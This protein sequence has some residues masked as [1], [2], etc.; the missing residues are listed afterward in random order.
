MRHLNKIDSAATTTADYYFVGVDRFRI[1]VRLLTRLLKT[2]KHGFF[3]CMIDQL[4]TVLQSNAQL[5]N[6]R[7]RKKLAR[8]I[9]CDNVV[10]TGL[11]TSVY[12]KKLKVNRYTDT[13][14]YLVLPNVI[15]WDNNFVIFLTKIF[16]TTRAHRFTD[17]ATALHSTRLAFGTI[18]DQIQ[19]KN[20]FGGRHVY[21]S[22]LKKASFFANVIGQVGSNT[23]T[24]PTASVRRY[25]G[26]KLPDTCQVRAWTTRHPNISQLSTQTSRIVE[27]ADPH[28]WNVKIGLGTFIGANRDCDGDK[29]VVTFMPYPNSL[30]DLEANLYGD[31]RSRFICFDKP[32]LAFVPQQIHYLWRRNDELTELF[33]TM[34]MVG[35]LWRRHRDTLNFGQRLDRLLEDATLLFSSNMAHLLYETLSSKIQHD[36]TLCTAVDIDT[37]SGQFEEL[38]DCGAKGSRLLLDSTA[39]YR[40]EADTGVVAGRAM[41]VLNNHI[42]SHNQVKVGGCD[43]YHTTTILQDLYLKGDNV[44]YKKD[45]LILCHLTSMPSEFLF[46]ERLL[47]MFLD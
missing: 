44:C 27:S 7:E 35:E 25:Y 17:T 5:V 14:D 40:S 9:H 16:H 22:T 46:P 15:S 2:A 26:R 47:D 43:I 45:N 21:R 19:N 30:L 18:K 10:V 28:N 36:Y 38:I 1:L 20:S 3:N 39:R 31:P 13:I 37:M 4:G 23:V 12:T 34:P 42:Q 8:L 11:E 6:D 32:R 33:D 41:E 29:E 24:P